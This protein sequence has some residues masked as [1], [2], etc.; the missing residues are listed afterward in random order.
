MNS[1]EPFQG[2]AFKTAAARRGRP[3]QFSI[4]YWVQDL[5][6][7]SDPGHTDVVTIMVNPNLDIVRIGRTFGS[8]MSGIKQL[9]DKDVSDEDKLGLMDRIVPPIRDALRDCFT[10]PSRAKWDLVAQD[11]DIQSMSELLAW[12]TGELTS[13]GPTSSVSSTIGSESTGPTSMGDA[14]LSASIS[15]VSRTDGLS[16]ST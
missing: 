9:N 7:D 10:P 16:S 3:I 11:Y 4:E 1:N 15:D 6:D 2:K 13:L 8:M 12:L 5:N 14:L